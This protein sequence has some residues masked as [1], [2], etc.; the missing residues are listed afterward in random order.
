MHDYKPYY[1]VLQT[2]VSHIRSHS[3][4]HPDT[5]A[6]IRISFSNLLA[7]FTKQGKLLN[8]ADVGYVVKHV[9]GWLTINA[10]SHD[11]ILAR[12]CTADSHETDVDIGLGQLLANSCNQSRPVLLEDK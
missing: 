3:Y 4:Y 5:L 1:T 7:R 9:L 2:F 8:T 10:N 6:S 12:L 11:S